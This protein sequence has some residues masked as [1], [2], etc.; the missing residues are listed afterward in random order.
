[1]R[2][3]FVDSNLSRYK[4]ING[5]VV[6]NPKFSLNGLLMYV[7]KHKNVYP[8]VCILFLIKLYDGQ[9]ARVYTTLRNLRL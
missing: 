5:T 9:R 6:N 3:F 1:M 2:F 4:K 8:A 7:D